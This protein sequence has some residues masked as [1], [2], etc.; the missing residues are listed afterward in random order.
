MPTKPPEQVAT[1]RPW[2]VWDNFEISAHSPD[3]NAEIATVYQCGGIREADE[4]IAN[5]ELIVKAVNAHDA[6]VDSARLAVTVLSDTKA[7]EWA[8]SHAIAA[9]NAALKAAEASK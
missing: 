5:A 6:L 2:R 3:D 1:P 7:D 8:R 4:A 9:L